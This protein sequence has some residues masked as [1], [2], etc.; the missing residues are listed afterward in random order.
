MRSS[1]QD[2]FER[3][4]DKDYD[5]FS[6]EDYD[7]LKV[8]IAFSWF[9]SP[10]NLT[11]DDIEVKLSSYNEDQCQSTNLIFDQLAAKSS[12]EIKIAFIF[13]M[14]KQ[15]DKQHQLPVIRFVSSE[16]SE[17]FLDHSGKI[18]NACVDLMKSNELSE[19][20]YCY[21]VDGWYKRS[22]GDD[23]DD[24]TTSI[25]VPVGFSTSPQISDSQAPTFCLRAVGEAL[26]VE[27]MEASEVLRFTLKTKN[28]SNVTNN[29]LANFTNIYELT[30]KDKITVLY[31]A[32]LSLNFL[33]FTNKVINLERA[34]T[35][36]K[37]TQNLV[38]K[39][40]KRRMKNQAKKG[41]DAFAEQSRKELGG[42]MHGNAKT[43]KFLK[44]I[45][46]PDQY[47]RN[48]QQMSLDIA[49]ADGARRNIRVRINEDLFESLNEELIVNPSKWALMDT[50][51][52]TRLLECISKIDTS[53]DE[54]FD[55]I[56]NV[57]D[58]CNSERLNFQTTRQRTVDV[59]AANLTVIYATHFEMNGKVFQNLRPY[60]IERIGSV[61]ESK[62][63]NLTTDLI[64]CVTHVAE[65][66]G[67][68]SS[69]EFCGILE[70]SYEYINRDRAAT[71]AENGTKPSIVMNLLK[72]NGYTN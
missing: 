27:T 70:Y 6:S 67:C 15:C 31:E 43:I 49:N 36:I 47:F 17:L 39:F 30:K 65:K 72:R 63:R 4:G 9:G 23:N 45:K 62:G 11:A 37:D 40:S 20:L 58:I 16:K 56:R 69:G 18:Y 61:L 7:Y 53:P 25:N 3:L 28:I 57:K 8:K 41:F 71:A 13:L 66:V 19:C 55:H 29:D 26:G 24:N 52:R 33:F 2:Y 10:R 22:H 54:A 1:Q 51:Q 14:I 35:I 42:T 59:F 5:S 48:Y 50:K 68:K 44:R 32:N 38:M 34:P 64:K 60:E 46:N 21:P 12:T